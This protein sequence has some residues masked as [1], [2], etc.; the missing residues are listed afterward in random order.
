MAVTNDDLIYNIKVNTENSAK[1]MDDLILLFKDL[2]QEIK[3]QKAESKDGFLTGI[4]KGTAAL[5][6]GFFFVKE[7]IQ[8]VSSV[9]KPLINDYTEAQDNAMKLA[10]TLQLF[11]DYSEQNLESYKEWA[12]ELQNT[13]KIS[14]DLA[15]VLAT[16]AKNMG[17]TDEQAK[18]M[19]ETANDLA[20][21]T[22]EGIQQ[23][24]QSLAGTLKGNAR[25][26]G[27]Q[28]ILLTDLNE[29]Q[30]A[31][32]KGIER[33]ASIFGGQAKEALSTFSGQTEYLKNMFGELF[34]AI[35]EIIVKGFD[36]Q[37][38]MKSST[39][40]VKEFTDWISKNKESL[41]VWANFTKEVFTRLKD[42]VVGIF[43]AI[44]T[45]LAY[46]L[47]QML[48]PI[49]KVAGALEKFGIISESTY[50]NIAA[51][52]DA[53][54][55]TMNKFADDTVSSFKD[56]IFGAKEVAEGV[57]KIEEPVK[58]GGKAFKGMSYLTKE[59][60]KEVDQII[61][62]LK[63]SIL[64]FNKDIA[65]IGVGEKTQIE[66]RRKSAQA[67]LDVVNERLVKL[68]MMKGEQATLLKQARD[69][70]DQKSAK[71]LN[72]LYKKNYEDL[73]SQNKTM[74]LDL[75]KDYMIQTDL[76]DAQTTLLLE[77]LD[78]KTKLLA[79]DD[80][81]IA[82][83]ENQKDLIKAMGEVQKQKAGSAEYQGMVKAG[84]D[85]S[86]E[87]SIAFK[88]G[89]LG[90][91]SGL[92]SMIG[93][94]TAAFDGV[95]A[96]VNQ[97]LDFIPH[98]LDSIAGVFDKI[99]D[100]PN[101]ILQA[102]QNFFRSA[103][104]MVTN[105]IPNLFKAIPQIISTIINGIYRE[106]PKAFVE[107][108]KQLPTIATEFVNTMVAMAP[109][110]VKAIVADMPIL[111]ME[112]QKQMMKSMP[113]IAISF[114]KALMI[115]LPIAIYE[116]LK[117]AFSALFGF[118][119]GGLSDM[120]LIDS[121][122]IQNSVKDLG[123]TLSGEAS[124]L[125]A[126]MNLDNV[127][128]VNDYRQ[129]IEASVQ[130]GIDKIKS[131]WQNLLQGLKDAWQW[132]MDKIITPV[133]TALQK[134]WQWVYDVV[135]KPVIDTLYVVWQWVYDKVMK[136]VIDAVYAVYTWV[137]EKIFLPVVNLF[138]T[139]FQWVYN[140][141]FAPV[142]KLFN[143]TFLFV[144]DKIFLPIIKLFTD[145]F[146][147]VYDKIFSPIMKWIG[148]MFVWVHDKVFAPITESFT[149]MFQWAEEYIFR[150]VV[151]AFKGAFTMLENILKP[152][153]DAVKSV[154]GAKDTISSGLSKLDPTTWSFA[155]GGL[156]GE[157]VYAADGM[158][159]PKGTDTVPA[160]LTPGEFVVNRG[161]VGSLGM[162]AMKAINSGIAPVNQTTINVE[163]K[164]EA[165]ENIDDNFIRNRL[166][167][168]LKD[169]LKRASLD[170]NFI[171][172]QKGIR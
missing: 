115:E 120:K 119:K 82:A 28:A 155:K 14:D 18:K 121:E 62:D 39:E 31:T 64:G 98:I 67:E 132:V 3:K 49:T 65:A 66:E 163:L 74:M 68:K 169:E 90:M 136:P 10:K 71:E 41:I 157:T 166:M 38:S 125:F 69:L 92:S 99:T 154:S 142:I 112:F 78:A 25:A 11:G 87:I 165:R 27:E 44:E 53:A 7:A 1:S 75:N 56:M 137:Y 102:V 110:F 111:F 34:E 12:G 40:K 2:N 55:R 152:F 167:P 48:S 9:I 23:A 8:S 4:G 104:D 127:R 52:N 139:T 30:L 46:T 170:G 77:Q 89:A 15:M 13:T 149:K 79:L 122:S 159:I 168:K 108:A 138:T 84:T 153:I 24:F 91:M 151:S 156:V 126:V 81:G 118:I 83:L 54:N 158:F 144:Y 50:N 162:N 129:Q 17:L 128:A 73:S 85:I 88:D 59:A 161:A 133:I 45:M 63:K 19:V 72:E 22:G 57:Q 134:V 131:I 42:L 58:A 135:L 103:I 171:I 96:S 114:A 100:F 130:G 43:N 60:L 33:I 47:T 172:S 35:G 80:K 147:W 117:E 143:D 21:A 106:L 37:G 51:Y 61:K 123:K 164:I 107:L 86:N 93:A 36:F 101:R 20:A 124:N 95:I 32:G 105:F 146:Q 5:A 97:I 76:I 26:L 113:K 148:D 150:P 70:V 29:E 116:G 16:Q 140:N 94:M 6:Q 160:M 109:D 145:T 141:I